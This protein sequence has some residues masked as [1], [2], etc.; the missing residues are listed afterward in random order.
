M[1]GR[2]DWE[3]SS[4]ESSWSLRFLAS[5]EC[6]GA[7][8][9]V[10]RLSL[11]PF[12]VAPALAPQSDGTYTEVYIPLFSNHPVYVSYTLRSLAREQ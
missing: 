5:K 10:R 8:L 2:L 3:A 11:L 1:S 6:D 7:I 4:G 12:V 9:A